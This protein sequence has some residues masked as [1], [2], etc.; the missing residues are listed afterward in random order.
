MNQKQSKKLLDHAKAKKLLLFEGLWSRFFPAFQHLKQRLDNNDL[1][2]I[3]EVDIEFGFDIQADPRI[4][5]KELGGGTILD[6]GVYAIHL[7]QWV[8]RTDPVSITAKG[9]L[10]EDG[11]DVET[12]VEL[13]Y[14]ST[15]VTRFKTSALRELRNEAIIR[16]TKGTISV[17]L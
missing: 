2:D 16:G 7:S 4:S 11:V 9:T 10:N 3:Q 8:H 1:G 6:L 15:G 14:R 13:K 17:S 12:D 5:K